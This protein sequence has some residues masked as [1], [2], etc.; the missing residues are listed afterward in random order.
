MEKTDYRLLFTQKQYGRLLAANIVSRFGDSVDVIA[1]SCIMYEVTG[2]ESLMALV[3]GLNYLPT[4]FLTP[5]AGILADRKRKK[6]VMAAADVARCLLVAGVI[7][8]YKGGWLTPGLLAALTLLTSTIEAFRIPAG[9][10]MLPLLLEPDCY[11][12]GKAA[13]YAA[14]RLAELAGYMAAGALIAWLGTAGALWI[15]AATF[16]VSGAT[17]LTLRCAEH[18]CPAG[19]SLR[20]V[21]EDLGAGLR[22]VRQSLAVQTAGLL[23]LLINFCI[24]PLAV[25]QTPYVLDY[26][27]M[28]PGMLSCIKILMSLGMMLGAALAPKASRMTSAA[29]AVLAGLGM[30]TALVLM[31]IVPSMSGAALRLSVLAFSMLTVGAGGGILNVLISSCTMR[32]VPRELMGRVS[33]FLTALMQASMPM[34]SFLCSVLAVPFSAVQILTLFGLFTIGCY[35]VLA[36]RSGLHALD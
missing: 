28:G 11:K 7:L 5:A 19:R 16:L 30:G 36:G 13:D 22:F 34:A 20:A 32:A 25:F 31:G 9:N 27:Q 3:M 4:V 1:Y 33:G 14:S 23:G 12:L 18:P 15:D 26:L 29:L 35:A 21:G 24:M 2:S 10:A 8:L 6:S 17:I